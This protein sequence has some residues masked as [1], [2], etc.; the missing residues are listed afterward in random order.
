MRGKWYF[1]IGLGNELIL[2]LYRD[3][4]LDF[5][6]CNIGRL[7][8][9][10]ITV[11]WSNFLNLIDCSSC[12]I[13]YLYLLTH[14]IH[15]IDD[16]LSKISLC[17]YFHLHFSFLQCCHK[18]DIN[19]FYEKYHDIW[20]CPYRSALFHLWYFKTHKNISSIMYV[21]IWSDLTENKYRNLSGR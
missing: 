20:F 21:L 11:K 8:K 3:I 15:I 18:I 4:I 13:I 6:Y 16:Y 1:I 7:L 12:S 19:V 14:Y 17:K 10:C 9:G 2:Y 5:G